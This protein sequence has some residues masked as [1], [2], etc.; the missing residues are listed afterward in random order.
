MIQKLPAWIGA[1][2]FALAFAAGSINVFTMSTMMGQAVTHHSGNSSSIVIALAHGDFVMAL[3]IFSV[4]AAFISGSILSGYIIKDYHL[5]LGRR[6]GVSL[7]IE[8]VL[9][10]FAF[11]IL[12]IKPKLAVLFLA[13]AT[14]LQNAMA[15]T[16]SGA[17]IRTTHLTGLY[18]DL[19]VLL[20]N[21]L[22]GIDIPRKKLKILIDI[23]A[24]FILGGFVNALLYPK[25]GKR[26]LLIPA[27]ISVGLGLLYYFLRRLKKFNTDHA[28]NVS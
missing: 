24:G 12:D 7:I 8:A 26:V 20:G 22:A 13:M 16:Y 21:R 15:T 18:T 11:F 19:G 28:N 5:K 10:I 23:L 14:G 6:Y 1:G 25:M 17:V 27:G 2:S 9:I 4:L 3:Y